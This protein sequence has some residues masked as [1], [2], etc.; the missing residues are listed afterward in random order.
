M[1]RELGKLAL[2]LNEHTTGTIAHWHLG[3]K[4]ESPLFRDPVVLISAFSLQ[5]FALI[6]RVPKMTNNVSKHDS[7]NFLLLGK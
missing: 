1:E 6:S 3:V 7:G 5:N 4:P 2:F